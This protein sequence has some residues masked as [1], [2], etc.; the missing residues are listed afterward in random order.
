VNRIVNVP[1]CSEVT[2]G[3]RPDHRQELGLALHLRGQTAVATCGPLVVVLP[4]LPGAPILTTAGLFRG[5]DDQMI[6]VALIAEKVALLAD[7]TPR[8]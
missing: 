1:S 2:D 5:R 7:A 4:A 3:P 8:R 6:S